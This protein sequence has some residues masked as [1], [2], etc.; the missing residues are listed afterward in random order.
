MVS[1]N[2]QFIYFA[3]GHVAVEA[4]LNAEI[5]DTVSHLGC[6]SLNLP[7]VVPEIQVRLCCELT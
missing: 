1:Y 3:G 6:K 7:L 5:S 4:Q 2:D